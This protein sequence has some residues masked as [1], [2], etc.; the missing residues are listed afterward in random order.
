[1]STARQEDRGRDSGQVRQSEGSADQSGSGGHPPDGFPVAGEAEPGTLANEPVRGDGN[2]G[3]FLADDSG[4]DR[5]VGAG[6]AANSG[7]GEDSPA[8]ESEFDQI[9]RERNE[10]LDSLLRTQADFENYRKRIVK[11]Q[12]E[13]ADRATENLVRSLLPVLDTIDLALAHITGSP[14]LGPSPASEGDV[15]APSTAQ[16]AAALV[17]VAD[18]LK[19]SLSRQGLSRIEPQGQ[20]FDPNEHEAVMHEASDEGGTPEVLEVLRAGWKWKGRVL[21][22]AMVKVKG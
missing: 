18:G 5:D 10:F 14:P 15:L 21:R 1:M 4:E 8:A 16:E 22:A 6:G 2:L 13:H 11:Q 20:P 9:R 3:S 7:E 19:E 17:Q 12:A